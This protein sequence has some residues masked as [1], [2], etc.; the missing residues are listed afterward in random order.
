MLQVRANDAARNQR[1]AALRRRQEEEWRFVRG[2][3]LPLL[4][5]ML[6]QYPYTSVDRNIV[7]RTIVHLLQRVLVK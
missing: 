5:S 4:A 1:T 2:V 7:C 6:R 3:R